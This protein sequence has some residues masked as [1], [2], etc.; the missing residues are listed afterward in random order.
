MHKRFSRH[1]ELLFIL[2]KSPCHTLS[3]TFCLCLFHFKS[4][5]ILFSYPCHIFRDWDFLL[6]ELV[7]GKGI[8]KLNIFLTLVSWDHFCCCCS[9]SISLIV[10]FLFSQVWHWFIWLDLLCESFL[11]IAAVSL[12]IFVI[13]AFIIPQFLCYHFHSLHLLLSIFFSTLTFIIIYKEI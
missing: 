5:I 4:F 8:I 9:S 12:W 2:S 6:S 7:Q 3:Y 10:F 11:Y 13:S 1:F